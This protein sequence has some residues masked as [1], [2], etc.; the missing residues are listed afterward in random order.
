MALGEGCG[1]DLV[2]VGMSLEKGYKRRSFRV[3]KAQASLS[4][5]LLLPPVNLDAELPTTSPVPCLTAS[6]HDVMN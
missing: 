3:S 2:G 1:Y 5:S 4:V 6:H